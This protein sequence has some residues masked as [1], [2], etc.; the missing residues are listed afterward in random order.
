MADCEVLHQNWFWMTIIDYCFDLRILHGL[1]SDTSGKKKPWSRLE[2]LR[3]SLPLWGMGS[4]FQLMGAT[5]GYAVHVGMFT[6]GCSPEFPPPTLMLNDMPW[7]VI[8]IKR[9]MNMIIPG[10]WWLEHD[11]YFPIQCGYSNDKPSKMGGLLLLYSHY[12]EVHKPN[13]QTLIFFTG[14]G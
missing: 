10:W 9:T 12:W 5:A 1:Q 6:L 7:M 14:V 4:S 3:K 11:L 2:I 13:W 8:K